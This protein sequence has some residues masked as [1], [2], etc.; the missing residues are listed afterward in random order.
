MVLAMRHRPFSALL[1][2]FLAPFC[3][4]AYGQNASRP[5]ITGISHIAVYAKDPAVA[6][7]FYVDKIGAVRAPDPEAKSG[8]RY[9]INAEQFIEVLPLT[10]GAGVNRLDH[11]AYNTVNAEALRAYLARHNVD[12]PAKVEHATD[13][14]AWFYVHDPEGNRVEFMQP[15]AH[16]KQV[17]SAKLVGHRLIHVGM[18]V[19]DRRIEDDFYR[20]LLGFRPYWFGGMQAGKVDWVSQQ[21]P[22]GSDWLEYML[23]SGP[24]GAGIPAGISQKQL[25]V[26]NHFS[27][28]VVD[29]ERAYTEL[30][31]AGR[32]VPADT[33]PQIGR[34][35]KRQLNVFDSDGTRVEYMEYGNVERPCCSEFT[36]ANPKPVE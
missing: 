2:G 6:R 5:A 12:A 22:E 15:P 20:A 8:A 10:A 18:L 25:G 31:A 9:Y 23:T 26:L 1:F 33:Y 30:H 32:L 11:L 13:G 36:A 3:A 7:S 24:S 34:D 27:I 35:G 14:S 21:V 17:S 16:P 28:G 4:S 29:M 19:H